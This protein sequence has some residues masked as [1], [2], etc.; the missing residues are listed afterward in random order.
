[1]VLML[2]K[3]YILPKPYY[4]YGYGIMLYTNIPNYQ[5]FFSINNYYS[6]N[7]NHISKFICIKLKLN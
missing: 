2:E 1:M 6:T 3:Q 7:R 5:S 4:G